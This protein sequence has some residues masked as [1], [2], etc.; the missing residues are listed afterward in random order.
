MCTV[1]LPPG[2][3]PTTVNKY[4][5]SDTCGV[6]EIGQRLITAIITNLL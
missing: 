3:Y 6:Y 2:G 5:M 1:L 4:I